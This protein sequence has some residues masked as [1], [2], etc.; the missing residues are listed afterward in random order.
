MRFWLLVR[1]HPL[2]A[3]FFLALVVRL[4]NVGLLHGE[5]AFF[6]EADAVSY[7]AAGAALA[8][9]DRF[10]PTLAS[11]IDRMPLYP[12]LLAAVRSTL[13]PCRRCSS[14]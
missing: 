7:W 2:S 10:W 13:Q 1:T 11:M 8:K 9:G 6:A 3:V 14:C 4:I 5:R 12:L